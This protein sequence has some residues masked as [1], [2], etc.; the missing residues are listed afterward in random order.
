MSEMGTTT[1]AKKNGEP[2]ILL[3]M[4]E[5]QFLKRKEFL[6]EMDIPGMSELIQAHQFTASWTVPQND[7]KAAHFY[8]EAARLDNPEGNYFLGRCYQDGRGIGKNLYMAHMHLEKAANKSPTTLGFVTKLN[9]NIGVARAQQ[10]LGF[11]NEW[12]IYVKKDYSKAVKFYQQAADNGARRAATFLAQLYRDGKGVPKDDQMAESYWNKALSLG[13]KNAASALTYHYLC[14]SDV[15]KAKAMLE[16]GRKLRNPSLIALTNENFTLLEKVCS[17]K[18]HQDFEGDMIVFERRQNLKISGLTLM[19]RIIR[20]ENIPKFRSEGKNLTNRLNQKASDIDR[21]NES[22]RD[23]ARLQQL[24]EQKNSFNNGEKEEIVDILYKAIITEFD[25]FDKI[26]DDIHKKFVTLIGQLY[27]TKCVKV[28]KSESEMKIRACY[29]AFTLQDSYFNKRTL[30][31]I[32]KKGLRCYPNNVLFH[33]LV[34]RLYGVLEEPKTGLDYVNK[35]LE[36]FPDHPDLL[37]LKTT[38]LPNVLERREQ[39]MEEMISTYEKYLNGVPSDNWNVPHAYYLMTCL[40]IQIANNRKTPNKARNGIKIMKHYYSLGIEAEERVHPEFQK[41]VESYSRIKIETGNMLARLE[42]LQSSSSADNGLG[43]NNVLRMGRERHP[44]SVTPAEGVGWQIKIGNR[45]AQVANVF[46][47]ASV[48]K[49][50]LDESLVAAGCEPVSS[51]KEEKEVAKS[52][53][54]SD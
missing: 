25:T 14:Q 7:T 5:E 26:S 6:E 21:I 50:E 11:M 4:T 24:F 22:L 42:S 15:E 43:M 29:I 3:Q 9:K 1:P 45:P 8:S 39:D 51:K 35:S 37:R 17:L 28:K 18:L 44:V 46:E 34:C 52:E 20:V 54:A 13:D 41:R 27:T 12:G 30:L 33:Y 19:D 49:R 36:E 16:K 10:E 23:V 48:L 53:P 32:A 38:F 31:L 40:Y 47:F 2:H